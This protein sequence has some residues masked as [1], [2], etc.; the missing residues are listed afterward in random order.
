VPYCN[1][2]GFG[3]VFLMAYSDDLDGDR[4]ARPMGRLLRGHRILRR[5]RGPDG[6]PAPLRG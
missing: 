2:E 1:C 6:L 5:S 4:T 3:A